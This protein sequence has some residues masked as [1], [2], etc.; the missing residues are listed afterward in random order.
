MTDINPDTLISE[1]PTPEEERSRLAYRL[2]AKDGVKP[3]GFD[4]TERWHNERNEAMVRLHKRLGHVA[5][6]RLSKDS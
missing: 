1:E 4:K 6:S 2:D 3:A 5:S